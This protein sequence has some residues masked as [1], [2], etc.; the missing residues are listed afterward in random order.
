MAAFTI[1]ATSYKFNP[2]NFLQGCTNIKMEQHHTWGNSRLPSLTGLLP[3][4]VKV[5]CVENEVGAVCA[6]QVST[7][8]GVPTSPK[9]KK[10][11]PR[12]PFITY[13][14]LSKQRR[15]NATIITAATANYC[16]AF[17]ETA[18]LSSLCKWPYS[19]EKKLL[20]RSQIQCGCGSMRCDTQNSPHRVKA[21]HT[22]I[23]HTQ[24]PLRNYFE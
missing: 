8:L 4:R 6:D 7:S 18:A 22:L 10:K 19:I 9:K 1:I 15:Q 16:A 24:R 20:W 3:P 14:K 12:E 13:P 11:T 23:L 17:N 5:V 2:R 21:L